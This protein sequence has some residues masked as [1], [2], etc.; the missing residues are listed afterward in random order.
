M[1]NPGGIVSFPLGDGQPLSFRSAV[2]IAPLSTRFAGSPN[3]HKE[4]AA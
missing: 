4:K 1:M 2:R 3:F